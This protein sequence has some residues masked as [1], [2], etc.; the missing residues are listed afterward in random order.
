MGYERGIS[1]AGLSRSIVKENDGDEMREQGERNLYLLRRREIRAT[2]GEDS[3]S[4][5]D[6]RESVM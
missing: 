3:S 5:E 6:M 1:D 4:G 2:T